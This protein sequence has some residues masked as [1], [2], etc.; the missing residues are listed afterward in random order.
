[1]FEVHSYSTFIVFLLACFN[2]ADI[3]G[4]FRIIITVKSSVVQDLY[5]N[6]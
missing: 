4:T 3:Y 2:Q 6:G 5:N 1:M